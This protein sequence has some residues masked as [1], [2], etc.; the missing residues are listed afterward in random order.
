[1]SEIAIVGMACQFPDARSPVALWENVLA[2]RR[3][4][5][6]IPP[7]RLSL[8]DYWSG[9]RNAPDSTYVT[10]A[11]LIAG[12]EFDRVSFRVTGNAFRA[13]DFVHWLALDVATQALQDAGCVHGTGLPS[14][15]TGVLVGNTLTGEFSRANTLR[16]RW[17]YVRRVVEATLAQTECSFQQQFEFLQALEAAYKEPFPV[18]GEETLAGNLSNTIAGRICNHYD[19]KGGGYSVDGACSSSLLAVVNGCTALT[20]GDLDVALVGG[21][22]ISLDPFE[23]IG[24]AKAGA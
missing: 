12:Y 16:L 6:R 14:E 17:P 21:I 3:S 20:M 18:T 7:E 11:A 13:A 5:R 1:M 4:F 15:R 24:F 22:D 8:K 9:D 2:Q 23:L 19:F 10:E